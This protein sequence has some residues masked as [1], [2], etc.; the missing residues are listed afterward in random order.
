MPCFLLDDGWR[1]R[2]R[3]V[4]ALIA[5]GALGALGAGAA[6]DA[7][8]AEARGYEMVS[9]PQKSNGGVV[10]GQRAADDG[11]AVAFIMNA[12]TGP[13]DG[14]YTLAPFVSRRGDGSWS[15]FGASPPIK[16]EHR[17]VGEVG[18]WMRSATPDFSRVFL[19]TGDRIDP[20]DE[21]PIASGSV[22]DGI[23][24]YEF[25][26]VTH[27][28]NWLSR[29]PAS[30]ADEYRAGGDATNTTFLGRSLD[31]RHVVF[32][33]SRRMTDTATPGLNV[34]IYE[35]VDGVVRQVSIRPD[36]NPSPVATAGPIADPP[37]WGRT[38]G[39]SVI[40]EDGS[41]IL[42]R[43]GTRIFMRIDGNRTIAISAS[44][45]TGT[46]GT[47][48][49]STFLGMTPD[50]SSVYF[51]SPTLLTD[52][53]PTGGG[54][55]RFDTATEVLH[56][57]APSRLTVAVTRSY[58]P[59]LSRDGDRLYFFSQRGDIA[60]G[61]VE[62]ADNLYL[63]ENG[64]MKHV[65]ATT[66]SFSAVDP[67]L[68]ATEDGKYAV[69]TSSNSIA[70]EFDAV[71]APGVSQIYRYDASTGDV[72]CVSCRVDGELTEGPA[73][74]RSATSRYAILAPPEL[75]E[76]RNVIHDGRVYFQ[77]TE[78]L[79]VDDTNQEV[80]VYEYAD[81]VHNL[82]S[83][84][85]GSGSELIDTSAD[86]RSVFFTTPDS[87]VGWDVDGG[88]PDVY[89]AR[90]GGGFPEPPVRVPS[91]QG[92]SCQGS[93][94]PIPPL[95]PPGSSLVEPDGSADDPEPTEVTFRPL[96]PTAAQLRSFARSGRLTLRVQIGGAGSVLVAARGR[97]GSRQREVG[98]A[99]SQAT[100]RG[101]LR[102]SV[103][104]SRAALTQLSK[105]RGL[106]VTA[107]IRHSGADESKQI[108]FT[109]RRAT[110]RAKRSAGDSARRNGR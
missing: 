46:V 59:A 4:A 2:S 48:A 26:P 62:G 86:G 92:D 52:D 11:S 20:A 74:L 17:A 33:S 110:S 63:L 43:E 71:H 102:I 35:A 77:T 58:Q 75:A 61:G 82:I 47:I 57:I 16:T 41:R 98:R 54:F 100:K 64:T 99:W 72:E 50:G 69:F 10:F 25:D 23:D 68:R 105:K 21:E 103:P 78:P 56:F 97:I 45:R 1:E 40:S 7:V 38:A 83:T 6:S 89:V 36:G 85:K 13:R 88:Y 18:A 28:A 104:L 37:L 81:G 108:S 34:T 70:P 87:L 84:G 27:E 91:C 95:N 65:A 106:R 8:A 3:V 53:T 22:S 66:A 49:N 67:L 31:G 24:F 55:Y 73:L 94:S 19:M 80:D 76:P 5:A 60:P 30:L 79:V 12:A 14:A 32:T 29:P 9:P 96:K 42:F 107:V 101:T 109:L 44:Q 39:S 93:P 90:E 51:R 15:T